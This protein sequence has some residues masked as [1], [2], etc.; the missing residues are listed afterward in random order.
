MI[1]NDILY[2]KEPFLVS[3][4]TP[5]PVKRRRQRRRRAVRVAADTTAREA[6]AQWRRH[7]KWRRRDR[8]EL[9]ILVVVGSGLLPLPPR[10]FTSLLVEVLISLITNAVVEERDRELA[11][12]NAARLDVF[13]PRAHRHHD[14]AV[15]VLPPGGR[16]TRE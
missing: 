10:A 6:A 1:C 7:S 13:E 12:R 14:R 3:K 9:L 15:V 16:E 11:P 5:I 4:K 8:V 2:R